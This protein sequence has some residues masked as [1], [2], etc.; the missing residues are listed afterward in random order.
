M[1]VCVCVCVC[2]HVCVYTYV[3]TLFNICNKILCIHVFPHE[4]IFMCI[5]LASVWVCVCVGARA[6]VYVDTVEF[7]VCVCVCACMCVCIN[8]CTHI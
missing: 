7:C 2:M 6:C 5:L 3:R 4:E 1:C 8:N